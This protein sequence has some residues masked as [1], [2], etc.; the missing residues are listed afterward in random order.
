MD[1]ALRCAGQGITVAIAEGHAEVA[2]GIY[3]SFRAERRHFSLAPNQFEKLY[4]M[5]LDGGEYE[6]ALWAIRASGAVGGDERRVQKGILAVA[7]GTAAGGD[8][9][10]ALTFYEFFLAQYPD[11]RF[12]DYCRDKADVLRRKVGPVDDDDIVYLDFKPSMPAPPKATSE[13]PAP[14]APSEMPSEV[15]LPRTPSEVSV[16]RTPSAPPPRTPSEPPPKLAEPPPAPKPS[17]PPP[18]PK[19]AVDKL[20]DLDKGATKF[21][22]PLSTPKPSDEDADDPLDLLPELPKSH[23]LP[24]PPKLRKRKA[25][26]EEAEMNAH[27]LEKTT[28]DED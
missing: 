23:G 18:L 14:R 1:D 9:R 13:S 21:G 17:Q 8:Q 25:E 24:P 6:D 3:R 20:M 22:L 28:P 10:K 2:K 16:P 7:D 4:K 19:S 11:S 15:P 27:Q 12:T 26:I 5:L